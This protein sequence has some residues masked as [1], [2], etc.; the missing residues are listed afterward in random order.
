MAPLKPSLVTQRS[1]S[2]AAALRIGGRQRRETGE[3]RR[4][5]S[6]RRV[7]PIVDAPRQRDRDVG[8][9]LLRGR[10]AMGQHLDVDAGLVHFLDA[11]GAEVF[12]APLRLARAVPLRCR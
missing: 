1:S 5:G 10:R 3:P 6:D 2:A 12:E 11:Q 9:D 4:I 7:Q 8:G